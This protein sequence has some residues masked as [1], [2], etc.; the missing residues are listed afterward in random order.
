MLF[1]YAF[2]KWSA[3][4]QLR[5][6]DSLTALGLPFTYLSCPRDGFQARYID[7]HASCIEDRKIQI[8]V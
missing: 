4:R 3:G 8:V 6:D 1:D 2:F 7:P 5:P